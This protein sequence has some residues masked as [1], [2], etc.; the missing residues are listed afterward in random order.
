VAID[1]GTSEI[2]DNSGVDERLFVYA[3]IGRAFNGFD[4]PDA[5][6][7][8]NRLHEHIQRDCPSAPAHLISAVIDFLPLKSALLTRPA[9][10]QA[11]FKR[12]DK[13]H[14]FKPDAHVSPCS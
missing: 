7:T 13:W 4:S 12:G 2:V 14:C 1:D 8:E 11:L 5:A 10:R 9:G 3:A 6:L